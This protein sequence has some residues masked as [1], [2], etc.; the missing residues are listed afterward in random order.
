MGGNVTITKDH[1]SISYEE[2]ETREHSIPTNARISVHT[3]DHIVAGQQL[4]EG[5]INPQDILHILGKEPTQEIS[6]R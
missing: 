3:G 2:N 1:I 5:S 4:T 6:G